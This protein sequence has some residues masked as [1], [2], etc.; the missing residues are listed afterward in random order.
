MTRTVL[1]YLLAV[2]L[3]AFVVVRPSYAADQ[4][5]VLHI[6]GAIGPAV[7]DYVISGI[8][9]ANEAGATIIVL[10]M[11]TPGGLSI[12][13]RQIIKAILASSV[14]VATYVA[15]SG[16][17]AASAGTYILYASHI[18]AMA[19]GTNLGAATPVNLISSGKP[20]A[21]T[22]KN[23]QPKVSAGENKAVNDATAYIRS[24]AQ[25]RD[26]NSTWAE[27]AV[28]EAASLSAKEALQQNVIDVMADSLPQ[29]LTTINGRTVNIQG[30]PHTLNTT[31]LSIKT[32]QPNWRERFLAVITNPTIAYLLLIVGF[33]GLF[34][35]FTHPGIIIPGVIGGIALL[36]AL[37]AFHM[38]PINYVGLALIVLGLLFFIMEA[39]VS[40]FGVLGLG[41]V[42]SFVIGSIML[43]DDKAA[44][45]QLSIGVVAGVTITS[46][47]LFI[48]IARMAWRAHRRPAV[49]GAA[50]LEG[51][52]GVVVVDEHGAWLKVSGEL[53]HIDNPESMVDGQQAVVT[54][55]GDMSLTVKPYHSSNTDNSLEKGE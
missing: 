51:H 52:L 23:S 41:G 16:A 42:I 7:A 26:R 43:F 20:S 32:V 8:D 25:L 9:Q 31:H 10:Q 19:P 28:T 44:G 3:M 40:T 39:F 2:V 50:F 53:W 47:L 37:Y 11:D 22:D 35:E 1:R 21:A 55:V 33:Y 54:H 24:L 46:G 36:L 38:L 48:V 45:Y 14:P 18:A 13:M 17:C 15:P 12:S 30:V 4:A 34:L 5:I 6:D 27:S 49:T 29:L